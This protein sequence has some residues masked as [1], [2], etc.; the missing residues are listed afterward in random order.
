MRKQCFHL[1]SPHKQQKAMKTTCCFFNVENEKLEDYHPY[2]KNYEVAVIVSVD[3][4]KSSREK[5]DGG[6]VS[7]ALQFT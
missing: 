1:Q 7:E 6:K 4:L 2:M 3:V 5:K